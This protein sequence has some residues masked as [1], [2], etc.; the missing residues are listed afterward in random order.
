MSLQLA[1]LQML[2]D[3]R[4]VDVPLQV[5]LSMRPRMIHPSDAEPAPQAS[6]P[7]NITFAL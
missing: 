4:R 6:S 2:E 5:Q 1:F 3:V 7:S